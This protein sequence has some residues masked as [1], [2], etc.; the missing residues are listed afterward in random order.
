MYLYITVDLL[1][2]CCCLLYVIKYKLVSYNSS[3]AERTSQASNSIVQS[4]VHYISAIIM[5]Q[6]YILYYNI[7]KKQKKQG[8]YYCTIV[9]VLCCPAFSNLMFQITLAMQLP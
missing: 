5:G 3:M 7:G 2:E 8:S 6:L 4:N 9:F 1:N